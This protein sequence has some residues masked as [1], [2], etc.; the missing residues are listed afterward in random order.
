VGQRQLSGGDGV[1][2]GGL[3]SQMGGGV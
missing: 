1:A 3:W 2:T